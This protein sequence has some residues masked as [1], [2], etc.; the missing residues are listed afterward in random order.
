MMDLPPA[1]VSPALKAVMRANVAALARK[2]REA[3]G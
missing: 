3:L 2:L 1:V